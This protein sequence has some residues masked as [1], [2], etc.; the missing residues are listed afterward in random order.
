MLWVI[1]TMAMPWSRFSSWSDRT[2]WAWV[3]TSSAVVGS[4]AIRSDG[5]LA[6]PMAIMTRWR[7]PP[8][9]W[10][11]YSFARCAAA[12]ILDR[13]RSGT[14]CAATSAGSK[15]LC[16]DMASS[17][18]AR[19]R[20]SGLSE[21]MAS[22]KLIATRSP[23]MR[24]SA[25]SSMSSTSRPSMTILPVTIRPGSGTRRMI[26]KPSV[27]LPQPDSPTTPTVSPAATRSPTP[28]TAR[29]TP[30]RPG[31]WVRR[32]STVRM[33]GVTDRAAAAAGPASRAA[34]RR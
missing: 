23:R 6:V 11:G 12:G 5:R 9:S 25:S 22:W 19:M 34:R 7:I 8:E 27:V 33:P 29:T 3:V 18:C 1:N 14:T 31:N 28:S 30:R 4:S 32:S 26:D 21:L 13:A 2:I 16:A 15:T 20:M 17:T 10:W 24:R